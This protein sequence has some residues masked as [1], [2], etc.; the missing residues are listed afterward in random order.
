[1]SRYCRLV[2]SRSRRSF[3]HIFFGHLSRCLGL[4]SENFFSDKV[5]WMHMLFGNP[6]TMV[7]LSDEDFKEHRVF[8][9]AFISFTSF[10]GMSH[11]LLLYFILMISIF[12]FLLLKKKKRKKMISKSTRYHKLKFYSRILWGS[13]V[14]PR[15]SIQNLV[16]GQTLVI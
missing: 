9:F 16:L 4:S 14:L 12:C 10:G 3:S 5:A 6:W 11:P 15:E 13:M 7:V 2:Q 1:M 8:C